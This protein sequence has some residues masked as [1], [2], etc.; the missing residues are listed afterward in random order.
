MAA[1]GGQLT[2]TLRDAFAANRSAPN[3]LAELISRRATLKQALKAFR[4]PSI[5]RWNTE[6]SRA[7]VLGWELVA[8]EGKVR[9]A[10]L[11]AITDKAISLRGTPHVQTL[12][13][14]AKGLPPDE[15]RW[16]SRANLLFLLVAGMGLLSAIPFDPSTGRIEVFTGILATALTV[17][18][19]WRMTHRKGLAAAGLVFGSMLLTATIPI[20]RVT[21]ARL[22]IGLV[23]CA[24]L[25]GALLVRRRHVGRVLAKAE[26]EQRQVPPDLAA[27][28]RKACDEAR[29]R[30]TES[31]SERWLMM[32]ATLAL[33]TDP[34]RVTL[35]DIP[36]G[37]AEAA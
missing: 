31:L 18:V 6:D 2:A 37:T 16:L 28:V 29:A 13:D 17:F 27:S 34:A 24:V 35:R 7:E 26:M 8:A 33:A 14:L 19:V 10:R 11:Q 4:V 3:V 22:L 9:D 23:L 25:A 21:S 1:I 15:Q 20:W 5:D 12:S 32:H 36:G 30:A